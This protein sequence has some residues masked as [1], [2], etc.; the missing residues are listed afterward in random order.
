MKIHA[1]KNT[2]TRI[3]SKVLFITTKKHPSEGKQT[4]LY[5]NTVILL[6]NKNKQRTNPNN[7][8]SELQ[9]HAE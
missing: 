7:N 4:A 5:L 8:M 1:H 6:N 2:C 3:F 9:K